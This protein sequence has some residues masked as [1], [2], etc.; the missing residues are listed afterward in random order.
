MSELPVISGAELV[1]R[2]ER[3]GWM[4]ARRRGSHVM[5]TTPGAR[6]TLSVPQHRELDRGTLRA[7]LRAAGI[8]AEDLM[9]LR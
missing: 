1:R 9:R 4:V 6:V 2:L 7:L 3:S 8:T 5:M